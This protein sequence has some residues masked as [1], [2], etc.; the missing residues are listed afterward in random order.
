MNRCAGQT[1]KGSLL[2]FRW[3]LVLLIMGFLIEIVLAGIADAPAP[4]IPQRASEDQAGKTKDKHPPAA[5]FFYMVGYY[6]ELNQRFS[7]AL[8]AYRLARE[9][10]PDSPVLIT[11]LVSAMGRSGDVQGAID[12]AEQAIQKHPEATDLRMLLGN[13]YSSLRERLAAIAQFQEVLQLDPMLEDAYLS[14]GTLYE[15]ERNYTA[16][17]SLLETLLVRQPESFLGYFHLA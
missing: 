17:R 9:Y 5:Y 8:A 13:L 14:L 7:E 16:A 2:L 15:E 3:V 6:H 10:D 11:S 4:S 12:L 1:A